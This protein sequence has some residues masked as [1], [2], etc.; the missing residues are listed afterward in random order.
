MEPTVEYFGLY[1]DA[2]P[3]APT[4]TG[5]ELVPVVI[6]GITN[7]TTTQ[8]IANLVAGTVVASGN[9]TVNADIP[10]TTVYTPSAPGLY[11]LAVAAYNLVADGSA[12]S[13]NIQLNY[14]DEVNGPTNTPGVSIDLTA[15]PPDGGYSQF[16]ETALTPGVAVQLS[17]LVAGIYGTATYRLLWTIQKLA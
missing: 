15:G 6:S 7:N 4:L 5:T 13:V 8:A 11:L 12:G 2:T 3:P 17:A 9:Q 16:I 14:T 1:V 10:L